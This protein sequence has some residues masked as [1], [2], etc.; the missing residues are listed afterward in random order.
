MNESVSRISSILLLFLFSTLKIQGAKVEGEVVATSG[1]I[2]TVS[3]DNAND[4]RPGDLTRIFT[5]VSGRTF[6]AATGRIADVSETQ[7]IVNIDPDSGRVNVGMTAV[8][9]LQRLVHECDELAADP[10]DIFAVSEGARIEQLDALS[11]V[12]ACKKAIAEYPEEARFHAQL[13]RALLAD[14]KPANAVLSYLRA[15]KLEPNY[16]VVLHNLAMIQR[17]GPEELQDYKAARTNFNA[18]AEAN[19]LESM[20]V[21]G[22]MCRDGLGGD[23]DYE[24]SFRWFQV[25]ADEGNAYAQ[26]ALGECFQ[27]G[28]GVEKSAGE[29]LLWFRSAAE[30]DYP[31]ALRN[32]GLAF[33]KGT[34]VTANDE[35]AFAWYKK[36][37]DL[38]DSP[39]QHAVG[40]FYLK[41]RAVQQDYQTAVDWLTK[42]ASQNEARSMRELGSLYYLGQVFKKDYAKAADYYLKAAELGDAASQFNFGMLLEKGQGVARDRNK[43]IAMFQKAARQ[44]YKLA[45][46][47]L[48]RLKKDW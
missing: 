35:K 29:A 18:A 19:F 25:A 2:V 14:Q 44:E 24:S 3:L 8:I 9:E 47:R 37:A 43:A 34:G 48:T 11:A 33:D 4:V 23:V 31:K 15:L 27:N 13:A 41:G 16:P 38:D 40:I 36:A 5:T 39:S 1:T 28:W 17:F 46:E 30:Q 6:V 12:G 21:L 42:A 45:Q 20:P 10:K 22:A 7:A 32:L 26:N